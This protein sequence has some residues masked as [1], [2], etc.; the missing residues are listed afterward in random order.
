MSQ[1]DLETVELSIDHANKSINLRNSLEKLTKNRDFKAVVLEGYFES[2]AV[3]LVLLK[4][5]PSM[6]DEESQKEIVKQIDAIGSFRQYLRTVMQLG[7]MASKAKDDY[8]QTREEL[9]AEEL[10]E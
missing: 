2:E 4:A 6:Q 7:D 8:E 9:L 1:H 5:D 3:R 10:S